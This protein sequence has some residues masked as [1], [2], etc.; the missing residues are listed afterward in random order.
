V[1]LT[2]K[3][4]VYGFNE[5]FLICMNERHSQVVS[6]Q[7]ELFTELI[8]DGEAEGV[9]AAAEAKELRTCINE[10]NSEEAIADVWAELEHSYRLLDEDAWST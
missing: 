5:E 2:A 6:Y 9:L 8:T 1:T 7:T 3:E 4:S 10:A